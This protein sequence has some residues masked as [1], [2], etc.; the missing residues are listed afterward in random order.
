MA[1]WERIDPE[2][3]NGQQKEKGRGKKAKLKG[4]DWSVAVGNKKKSALVGQLQGGRRNAV[5]WKVQAPEASM[6]KSAG[7][8]QVFQNVRRLCQKTYQ[9]RK[10]GETTPV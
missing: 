1:K 6:H 10:T 9:N 7:D 3:L 5:L 4:V 8:G 2:R